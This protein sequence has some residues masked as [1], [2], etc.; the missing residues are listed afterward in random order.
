MSKKCAK[1]LKTV[2]PTEELKCLDKIW[3]KLC[4]KCEVCGMTL[5]MKN[6]KGFEKLPYCSAHYPTTKP[7]AVAD[8]PEA[9]R[10][11]ENTKI[12]SNVQ[13][14]ADF[15]KQKGFKT[16]VADDPE[17][18]RIKQNTQIQSNVNYWGLKEQRE[19]MEGRR[20]QEALD[21]VTRR[22]RNPGKISDY[23]PTEGQEIDSPYSKRS[24]ANVVYDSKRGG[25]G[26]PRI[27]VQKGSGRPSPGGHQPF[28]YGGN[29]GAPPPM[30]GH[31]QNRSS[32]ED[33]G[34]AQR[35]QQQ[36]QQPYSYAQVHGQRVQPGS[37]AD[38]D[39]LNQHHSSVVRNSY[40]QSQPQAYQPAP[41]QAQPPRAA[42]AA[43][44]QVIYR[45]LYDYSAADNDEVSFMDGDH[46][47]NVE[48]VDAGWMIGTVQ[49]TGQHGMLPSNYVERI[50]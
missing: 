1:C 7:T 37:I 21:D 3:H 49:R 9:R 8:T 22:S 50:N 46:I 27:S 5:N 45:A 33:D 29:A 24:S 14:H 40:G 43:P 23:D 18:S 34:Y 32:Y 44:K 4:F 47:V 30:G 15:E 35:A 28:S 38:Y 10:I 31:S 25:E 16:S 17:T 19:Q 11:A 41:P 20:P 48:V 6:Y 42:Q 39:P 13:Y 26:E 2:Y 12:Q 36:S